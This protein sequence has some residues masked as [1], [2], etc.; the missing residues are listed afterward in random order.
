MEEKEYVFDIEAD[1]LNPTKI[2]C[3]AFQSSSSNGVI[4]DYS[5]MRDFLLE[6]KTLI[7]HNI[8]RFDIPVLERLLGIK[9][10]AKLVDTLALSWYLASRRAKHGLASYGEDF[11]VPKPEVND[12]YNLDIEIYKNRCSEDVKIN[13]HLWSDQLNKLKKI[14]ET[15]DDIWKFLKYLAFKM[16]CARLQEES[17]WKVDLEFT[18]NSLL[19]LEKLKQ[20]KLDTLSRAMPKVPVTALKKKPAKLHKANGSLSKAG[21]F[22]EQL[23][24]EKS[25]PKETEEVVVVTSYLDPNP[26][27]VIQI[28]DWLFSL[29]WK[30]RTFKQKDGREIPQIN[31]ENNKGLCDSIKEMFEDHPELEVLD[32]LSVLSHRIPVLKGFIATS[33][34]KGYVKAQIQGLTNTLRFQHSMPCVNLP[35]SNRPH[36][37]AI[38]GSLV[39]PEGYEL[40]GAD[41]SSLEDRLKQHFIFPLDP[42]YVRS[43]MQEDFDPHLTLA[44]MAGM[45]TSTEVDAYKAGDHSKKP[46]RDVAK[47]GNYA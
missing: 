47:N 42:D 25:L 9:I 3:L 23:L 38:R 14:Y 30:P 11:G 4:T 31:K 7:G 32:G 28:K 21:E 33:D 8:I 20:E 22:W 15:K 44:L 24:L 13:T 6:A 34:E 43:M 37:E 10:S 39:A 2:Y 45:M 16:H 40:C 41:M 46:V 36:A 1:G 17:G 12:W 27:S 26:G 18:R 5:E 19:E 29:G 35:R